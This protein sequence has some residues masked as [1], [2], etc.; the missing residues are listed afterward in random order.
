MDYFLILVIIAS[1]IYKRYVDNRLRRGQSSLNFIGAFN[2][3][4]AFHNVLPI[5]KDKYDD[6]FHSLVQKGNLALLAF[7]L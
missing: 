1:F 3:F 7:Y 2:P 4:A 5:R 6:K